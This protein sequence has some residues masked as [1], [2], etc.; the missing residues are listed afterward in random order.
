[1]PWLQARIK[2]DY[3]H[4][5]YIC[6]PIKTGPWINTIHDVLFLDHP[7]YFPLSYRLKNRLLFQASAMRSEK[8]FTVSQ[9]SRDAISRH[10][11]LDKQQIAVIPAAPDAFIDASDEPVDGLQ[12]GRFA[13]YVSRFEPRKNQH[14]LV[15]AFHALNTELPVGTKLVLVGYPALP[16]PELDRALAQAGERV[17]LL[18][19]ITN[20]QLTWLYRNA[21]ASIYPSNAEGFGMPPLEAVAA[22]GRSFCAD[23]TAMSE[24]SGLVQGQ[25]DA[26]SQAEIRDCVRHVFASNAHRP[27]PDMKAKLAQ[28]YSWDASAQAMIDALKA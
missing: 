3:A 27:D 2:P 18:S 9:F 25:F 16:Y 20:A 14:S 17:R 11:G 15:E 5:N 1:M 4:F 7:E 22:G 19:N 10:F 23:N 26:S 6:P 13:V 24:L 28:S 21:A 8:V 12:P